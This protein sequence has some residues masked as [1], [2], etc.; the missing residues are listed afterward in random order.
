MNN[1]TAFAFIHLAAVLSAIHHFDHAIRGNHVGWP[2]SDAVT[3][4][5]Y[6][7]GIYPLIVV[8]LLLSHPGKVGAGYWSWLFGTGLLFLVAVHFGPAALEPPRDIVNP[9]QSPLIGWLAFGELVV[10]IAVLA[11]GFVHMTHLWHGERRARKLDERPSC[12]GG[13]SCQSGDVVQR[14]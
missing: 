10:F 3:P 4:F 12:N 13:S 2:L 5:T 9:H 8:G 1:K 6:S 7:L 11:A 14:H